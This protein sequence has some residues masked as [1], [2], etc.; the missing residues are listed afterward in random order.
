MHHQHVLGGYRAIGL[1]L[2]APVAFGVL[3]GHDTAHGARDARVERARRG[4]TAGARSLRIDGALQ[5]GRLE[6]RQRGHREV[7][8][9]S[10]CGEY[11]V[12][13]SA[14]GRRRAASANNA[15]SS[16]SRFTAMR[17]A[18]ITSFTLRLEIFTSA[19]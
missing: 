18:A 3:R 7:R 12:R 6:R 5:S 1:E 10:L 14:G 8:C 16:R 2:V 15:W 11:G 4:L 9:G 17:L 19:P 13:G